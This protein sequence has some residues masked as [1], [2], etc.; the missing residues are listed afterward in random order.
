M[1]IEW[2]VKERKKGSGRVVGG[3]GAKLMFVERLESSLMLVERLE[4]DG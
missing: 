1:L 4:R 2:T 3:E